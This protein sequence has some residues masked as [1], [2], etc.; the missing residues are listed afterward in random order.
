MNKKTLEYANSILRT[1]DVLDDLRRIMFVPYPQF[2]SNDISVNSAAFDE[3]TL[4]KLKE[5]IKNF[6]DNR[7]T[8]LREEFENL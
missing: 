4:K 2:S 8:E 1:I 7:A 3:E 5:V 6:V